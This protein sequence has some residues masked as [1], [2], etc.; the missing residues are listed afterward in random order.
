MGKGLKFQPGERSGLTRRGEKKG[1][2]RGG[3]MD[4]KFK[5]PSG[6]KGIGRKPREDTGRD[7]AS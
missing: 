1:K 6:V 7:N 5:L 4:W 3:R 2:G